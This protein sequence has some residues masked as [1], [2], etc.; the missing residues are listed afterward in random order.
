MS[1]TFGRFKE[2][3]GANGVNLDETKAVLGPMLTMD[4]KAEIVVGNDAAAPLI[5]EKQRE[6][7]AVPEIT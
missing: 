6:P 3:L 5:R 4:P 2:H 7:F 1:E